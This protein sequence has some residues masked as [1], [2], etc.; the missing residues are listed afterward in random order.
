MVRK[1]RTIREVVPT[2]EEQENKRLYRTSQLRVQVEELLTFLRSSNT[3]LIVIDEII[4]KFAAGE[5]PSFNV[6]FSTYNSELSKSKLQGSKVEGPERWFRPCHSL[7]LN[8]RF[9]YVDIC[10]AIPR[11][12]FERSDVKNY[13]YF[14]K[15]NWYVERLAEALQN[16]ELLNKK[17][18]KFSV[19]VVPYLGDYRKLV[20]LVSFFLT[21]SGK[22][23]LSNSTYQ[24]I[25]E[26]CENSI[27]F[28]IFCVPPKDIFERKK[29]R[30][31]RRNVEDGI[32]S[33]EN[34]FHNFRIY[35][36]LAILQDLYSDSAMTLAP[37]IKTSLCGATIL[38]NYYL[39]K[40]RVIIGASENKNT[41]FGESI[42]GIRE[43]FM[44]A[45][46]QVFQLQSKHRI[47]EISDQQLFSKLLF[48][49]SSKGD[50]HLPKRMIFGQAKH[51]VNDL[52]NCSIYPEE[53]EI[54]M[55]CRIRHS[56][57]E[58]K[59]VS[60][61]VLHYLE[62]DDHIGLTFKPLSIGQDFFVE[63]ES[64]ESSISKVDLVDQYTRVTNLVKKVVG[65]EKYAGDSIR[66]TYQGSEGKSYSKFDISR[67]CFGFRRIRTSDESFSMT[68]GPK[69]T[70]EEELNDFKQFWGDIG[71][72]RRFKDGKILYV[73]DW[74]ERKR[75]QQG[76][77][78]GLE[79]IHP[80]FMKI[81]H[82]L[83]R[84][85]PQSDFKY[86]IQSSPLSVIANSHLDQETDTKIDEILEILI[87]RD[88][89][90]TPIELVSVL[91][92][93]PSM[94]NLHLPIE[95][96]DHNVFDT[97]A[98]FNELEG[99]PTDLFSIK[100]MKVVL[101][102]SIRQSLLQNCGIESTISKDC[103]VIQIT[104]RASLRIRIFHRRSLRAIEDA[105]TNPKSTVQ[106]SQLDKNLFDEL[107]EAWWRSQVLLHLNSMS[108]EFEQFR[109]T[110]QC[111]K[112]WCA[113]KTMYSIE[114]NQRSE[115]EP[116][117]SMRSI[118][119]FVEHVV[120]AVFRMS[121]GAIP[122]INSHQIGLMHF[123]HLV[124]THNWKES[125]LLVPFAPIKDIPDLLV[126][127]S[128]RAQDP[129]ELGIISSLDVHGVLIPTIHGFVSRRLQNLARSACMQFE[130]NMLLCSLTPSFWISLFKP[131]F[132]NFS[133]EIQL[134]DIAAMKSL[135]KTSAKTNKNQEKF[136]NIK[137]KHSEVVVHNSPYIIESAFGMYLHE[138][139][140]RFQSAVEVFF[141]PSTGSLPKKLFIRLKPEGLSNLNSKEAPNF[142]VHFVQNEL[143]ITSF[144]NIPLLIT[145]LASVGG[146]I[147]KSVQKV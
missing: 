142:P 60:D 59:A 85:I 115:N 118:D 123:F 24:K 106:A 127:Y 15:R 112:L 84:H 62:S 109:P 5:I 100:K 20:I 129:D 14:Q 73:V 63:L 23:K 131:D 105:V 93:S 19:S 125:P 122:M 108:N 56:F 75:L 41:S 141:D 139:K 68:F 44:V 86:K 13:R 55:L 113:K 26:D 27:H 99:W 30:S 54:D 94:Y 128:A 88:L 2:L 107:R 34:E 82:I 110:L 57:S 31:T 117:S 81:S 92:T 11:S 104:E 72:I 146:E 32:T 71:T 18:G 40:F 137:K 8:D 67:L 83:Q 49:F 64:K 50:A 25:D 47:V 133:F 143:G 35:E 91:K 96:E 77:N 38:F 119:I 134:V 42:V 36:D 10:A 116:Y 135:I 101:L 103:L 51:I 21:D 136:A 74:N 126:R 69:L 98:V 97:W 53:V 78:Q 114:E 138:L 29:L 147:V 7:I 130:K 102:M 3:R 70:E 120:T 89:V 17:D 39:R 80:D 145:S 12:L 76:N 79:I 16:M 9:D 48:F 124:S 4:K 61:I 45:L 140:N 33:S 22:Y 144:A 121:E 66:V 43:I 58:L 95:I 37:K 87:N 28:R 132:E 65:S 90:K 1:K 6:D 111:V 46:H 52:N